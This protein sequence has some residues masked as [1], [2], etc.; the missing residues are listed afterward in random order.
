MDRYKNH[1]H[2]ITTLALLPYIEKKNYNNKWNHLK[3]A[4]PTL[5]NWPEAE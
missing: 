1:D 2:I 3:L 5:F 4:L